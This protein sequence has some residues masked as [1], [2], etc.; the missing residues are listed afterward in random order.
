MCPL[1][2]LE[3]VLLLAFA[4][5]WY[6]AADIENAPPLLWS[7]MATLVYLITWRVFHFGFP[8]NLA[9]QLALLAG[10]TLYQVLRSPRDKS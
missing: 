8:G 1:Y 9:G 6:K 7:G 10:I 4:G 5:F 3:F 2:S